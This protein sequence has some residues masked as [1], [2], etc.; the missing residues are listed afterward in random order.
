MRSQTLPSAMIK[1]ASLQVF[2]K[3]RDGTLNYAFHAFLY[4][5]YIKNMCV[6]DMKNVSALNLTKICGEILATLECVASFFFFFFACV[7]IWNLPAMCIFAPPF[8][9]YCSL[10]LHRENS[11]RD[12][13]RK[14]FFHLYCYYSLLAVVYFLSPS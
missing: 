9:G 7:L 4:Q 14:A 10:H 12:L 8:S 11:Q 1:V 13:A 2:F 5:Q 6:K 3:T